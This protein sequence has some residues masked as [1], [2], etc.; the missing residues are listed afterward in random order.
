MHIAD[1]HL[2]EIILFYLLLIIA[3]LSM[4]LFEI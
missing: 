1:Y 3:K 2:F 4:I